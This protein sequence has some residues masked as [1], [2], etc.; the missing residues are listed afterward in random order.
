MEGF[1]AGFESLYDLT[2]CEFLL[3]LVS[4]YQPCY[5]AH[6]IIE[7]LPVGGLINSLKRVFNL[8]LWVNVLESDLLIETVIEL[9]DT[10]IHLF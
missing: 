4:L 3:A 10:L 5:F 2:F 9:S 8:Y 1:I 7:Q 6:C